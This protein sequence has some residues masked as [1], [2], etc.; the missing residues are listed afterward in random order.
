MPGAQCSPVEECTRMEPLYHLGL[1]GSLSLERKRSSRILP[2]NCA[3]KTLIFHFPPWH[4]VVGTG[5][6]SLNGLRP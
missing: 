3:D 5:P 1:S 4:V 2:C 6:K